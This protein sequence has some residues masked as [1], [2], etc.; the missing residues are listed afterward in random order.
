MAPVSTEGRV[1]RRFL[2]QDLQRGGVLR[3]D[4]PRVTGATR[5]Q[6]YLSVAFALL[7]AM[8]VAGVY[9]FR[10]RPPRLVV[11]PAIVEPRS[12]MLVRAIATLDDAFDRTADPDD[13]TCAAY[14]EKR[15]LLKRQLSDALAAERGAA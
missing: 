10:R 2:A 9:A 5:D 15:A 3:V 13:A 14:A 12:Q 6:V 4:V 7:A 11:A 8:G 1:F